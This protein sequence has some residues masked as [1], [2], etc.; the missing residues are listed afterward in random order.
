[1]AFVEQEDILNMFEGLIK[2]LFQTVRGITFEGNFPRM[3]YAEA[4]EKYGSDKPDIRFGMEFTDLKRFLPGKT[5]R[6]LT[7]QKR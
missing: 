2:H 1:M 3:T 4:M 7:M 6:F 5:S